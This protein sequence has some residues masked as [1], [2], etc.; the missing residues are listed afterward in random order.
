MSQVLCKKCNKEFYVKPSHQK[1]G[2]GKYCSVA[3][4]GADKRTG[5]VIKC[6]LCGEESYKQKRDFKRS[7]SGKYFCSKPCQTAWR[8]QEFS[9]EKHANSKTGIH[10]YR[11]VLGRNNIQAK[12][13]LCETEDRRVLAVHHVDKNKFNN[14]LE[15]LAYLCHNCHHLVHHHK[16]EGRKFS[17]LFGGNR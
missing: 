16:K 15:N 6:H 11:S 1:M 5:K 3:C 14:R 4:R 17:K 9:G 8:N 13:V 12:C 10:A 7:K 2:Y